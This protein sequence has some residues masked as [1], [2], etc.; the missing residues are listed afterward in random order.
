MAFEERF[1][2]SRLSMSSMSEGEGGATICHLAFRK[3]S[4]DESQEIRGV[5]R[6]CRNRKGGPTSSR[7]LLMT[8]PWLS[9]WGM[10]VAKGIQYPFAQTPPLAGTDNNPGESPQARRGDSLAIFS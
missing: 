3:P 2:C 9:E 6:S 4:S 7:M 5:T 8:A 10:L 1:C